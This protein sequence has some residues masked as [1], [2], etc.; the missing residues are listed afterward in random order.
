MISFAGKLQGVDLT[1]LKIRSPLTRLLKMNVGDV[2]LINLYH[3][4]RHLNQAKKIL[5]ETKFPK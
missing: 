4:K 1:K 5:D 3:D 2:L